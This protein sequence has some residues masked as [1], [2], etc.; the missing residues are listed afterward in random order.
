MF[1]KRKCGIFCDKQ[2]NYVRLNSNCNDHI[3]YK[4]NTIDQQLLQINEQN[5][6]IMRKLTNIEKYFIEK[7]TNKFKHLESTDKKTIINKKINHTTK[8]NNMSYNCTYIS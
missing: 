1:K 4:I 5:Y 3:M 7:N 8:N 2:N 6:E